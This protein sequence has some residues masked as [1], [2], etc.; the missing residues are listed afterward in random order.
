M[1]NGG[2]VVMDS[3]SEDGQV[4]G[5]CCLSPPQPQDLRGDCL[6]GP[7]PFFFLHVCFGSEAQP[8]TS[9]YHT[10]PHAHQYF[11]LSIVPNGQ[12][13]ARSAAGV[14]ARDR[15]NGSLDYCHS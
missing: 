3:Q 5:P 8:R 13:F 12:G 9:P 7:P 4:D 1:W 14:G 15:R 2:V 10:L 6:P 11:I